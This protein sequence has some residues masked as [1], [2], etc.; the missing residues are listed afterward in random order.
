MRTQKYFLINK[1]FKNIFKWGSLI[2]KMN[3]T[4]N[5]NPLK[6]SNNL[7]NNKSN[8]INKGNINRNSLINHI[9][10]LAKINFK[11]DKFKVNNLN[12]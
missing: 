9:N 2:N 7:Q 8:L 11:N 6:T 4:N 1:L 12:I 3:K 10:S 5:K